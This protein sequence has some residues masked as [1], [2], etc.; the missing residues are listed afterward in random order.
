MNILNIEYLGHVYTAQYKVTEDD[1]LVV[2][3]PNG[4][5]RET[6][7]R[8]IRPQLSAKTHLVA[9]A[10]TQTRSRH[11]VQARTGHHRW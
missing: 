4:E 7:L 10:M 3:L 9:Y 1:H 6:A 2:H 11:R 5:M 8:G